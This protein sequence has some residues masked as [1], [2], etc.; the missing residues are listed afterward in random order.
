M[1]PGQ[2]P[3]DRA[4]FG[5]CHPIGAMLRGDMA[6]D[7]TQHSILLVG[8]RVGHLRPIFERRR[9]RVTAV[10]KGV[11]GMAA[12]DSGRHHVVLLELNLGD[13]TA[14]E[15]LM[16]ARQAHASVTFLL[17]DDQSKASQIVKAMQAGLDGYLAT[18]PDED[19]LFF[20]VERH[21]A[22]RAAPEGVTGPT[23]Q[24]GFRP[25]VTEMQS[26]LL[27]RESALVEMS[28]Q[29][30]LLQA[31][32]ARMR[33][34]HKRWLGVETAL[35]GIT[36]GPLDDHA[37]RRLKERL[38][39]ASVA[40]TEVTALREELHATK[41]ARRHAQE[42]CE[43]LRERV[44][45]LEPNPGSLDGPALKDRA[46]ELEA[47]NMVMA[48][49][50]AELEEE[51]TLAKAETLALHE[52]HKADVGDLNRELNRV[53][54][55]QEESSGKLQRFE[56]DQAAALTKLRAEHEATLTRLREEHR[57]A[58]E[59]S[60]REHRA[61]LQ[62]AQDEVRRSST[63]QHARVS[64]EAEGRA[65][66][67]REQLDA[68]AAER[69]QAVEKALDAEL[70]LDDLNARIAAL[71]DEAR[72]AGER[73][74][75]AEAD[76]KRD[77][78]RLVEEKEAAA[79]GSHEAFERIQRFAEENAQL[80]RQAAELEAM[81]AGL[82]ER[83]ARG[84]RIVQEAEA[85][86]ADAA[87]LRADAAAVKFNAEADRERLEEKVRSTERELSDARG[88]MREMQTALEE[89]G[90]S[91]ARLADAA[92]ARDIAEREVQRLTARLADAEQQHSRAADEASRVRRQASGSEAIVGELQ[93]RIRMLE[94]SLAATEARAGAA[95]AR[96]G[97][98]ESA[99]QS[100]GGEQRAR[101][102]GERREL[103]DAYE[104]RLRD[105]LIGTGVSPNVAADLE[106]YK[107]RLAETE[108]WVQQA[109]LHLQALSAERE[110]LGAQL[111]TVSAELARRNEDVTELQARFADRTVET[112]QRAHAELLA[113]RQ[114][115]AALE[116]SSAR[117]E[118]RAGRAEEQAA[119][120][121]RELEAARR[122]GASK[123]VDPRAF[124]ELQAELKATQQELGAVRQGGAV[125]LPEELEPLRW[126]LKAAIDALTALEHREPAL[127]THLRNLR[128]LASTLQRIADG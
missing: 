5:F 21:L 73:A 81:R 36:D 126:T 31:E 94:S 118:E 60:A 4:E 39:L 106:A 100:S 3:Q 77:K 1:P 18:P 7:P 111:A 43:R 62:Q 122:E 108:L 30:E 101:W 72:L 44:A 88:R 97:A 110:Q 85:D 15:F 42:E 92:A 84:D 89:A 49:R 27:S 24:I 125:R 12:L 13:L 22:A 38:A 57:A 104:A 20:E 33:D 28:A 25:D 50:V 70:L 61:G 119:V 34:A 9:Y 6:V 46:T 51:L 95:E 10:Y 128:L 96:A 23:T 16:A 63:A 127:A 69:D 114:A 116:A 54:A 98:A 67:L 93:E 115:A 79:S 83:A 40:E 80:K 52:K 56:R 66:A 91:V 86:R 121:Q 107:S 19:R 82:E 55:E 113:A 102:E 2:G 59:T 75:K 112:D 65:R 124:A 26:Q 109:Q 78:L 47:D 32:V 87:R 68:A 17:I 48:G 11:E 103:V 123:A 120:A 76:F 35:Q 90:T 45:Q 117:A 71:T 53:L 14:T 41:T 74:A 58:I 29:T 99:A 8:P 37:A 105:A 64:E